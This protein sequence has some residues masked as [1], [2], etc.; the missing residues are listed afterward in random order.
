MNDAPPNWLPLAGKKRPARD[1]VMLP[2]W[3]PREMIRTRTWYAL[4]LVMAA[5]RLMHMKGKKSIALTSAVWRELGG[6]DQFE[7]HAIL[8]HLKK[9]PQVMFMTPEHRL[10]SRYRLH[11][12][13]LWANPPP[14]PEPEDED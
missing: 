14:A 7:R 5:H 8:V 12:G 3:V 10:R 2:T 4:P 6:L 1:F 9:M 13:P 11:Y